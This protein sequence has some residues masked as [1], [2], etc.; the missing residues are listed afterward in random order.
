MYPTCLCLEPKPMGLGAYG[1]GKDWLGEGLLLSSGD[2]WARNRRLLTP[3][4]HFDVLKPYIAV[5]N[6]AVECLLV[7][8]EFENS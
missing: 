4:F 7:C 3:A 8:A 2:K 5:K 6:R 1:Y